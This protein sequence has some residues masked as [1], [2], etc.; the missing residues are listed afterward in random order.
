MNHDLKAARERVEA[1]LAI[2]D[3]PNA[4]PNGGLVVVLCRDLRLILAAL[5]DLV[6]IAKMAAD[7]TYIPKHHAQAVLE[8]HGLRGS[9]KVRM[10]DPFFSPVDP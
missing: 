7:G 3:N 4:I 6:P 10:A 5:D 1:D 9:L 8:R 2:F